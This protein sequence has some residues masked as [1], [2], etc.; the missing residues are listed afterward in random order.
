M[1]CGIVLLEIAY[2]GKHSPLVNSS[3]TDSHSH[4]QTHT[5]TH[6][7][8]HTHTLTYIDKHTHTHIHTHSFLSQTYSRFINIAHHYKQTHSH[9]Q[10]HTHT[11]TH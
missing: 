7:Y 8:K 6:I 11:H 2:I 4:R 10:T 5:L 3:H 1:G 9:G